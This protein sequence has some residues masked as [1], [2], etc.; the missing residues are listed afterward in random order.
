M[1]LVLKKAA[2]AASISEGGHVHCEPYSAL[3]RYK[4][5]ADR[6]LYEV[7]G[8][9]LE[10][11]SGEDA[12]LL[13]R[14]LDHIHVVDR[15]FKHH[16]CEVPHSFKAPRSQELPDFHQLAREA[17]EVDDWYVSYVAHLSASDLEQPVEFTYTNGAPAR[18]R[19]SEMILH[20]CLHGTYHR[21]NAGVI[22]QKNG[23][24]P[25]D[26]RM[27]DFLEA[28]ARRRNESRVA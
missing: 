26:D 9:N 17:A 18:M 27:T 4:Q 2:A 5:W 22:L 25:N 21:G 12:A 10:R 1:G 6:G 19:R 7:I 24:A 20:V 15:I 23:I 11:L 13:V 28:A 8:C 14:I 16:L 3:V